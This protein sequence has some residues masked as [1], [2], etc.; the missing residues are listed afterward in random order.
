MSVE[1][2]EREK[3]GEEESE[4]GTAVANSSLDFRAL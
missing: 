3:A 2:K 4:E 1:G